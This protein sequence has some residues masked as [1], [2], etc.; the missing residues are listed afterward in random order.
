MIGLQI[1]E[2]LADGGPAGVEPVSVVM[3][4]PAGAGGAPKVNH[5]AG[6]I[7]LRFE[8]HWVH[9]MHRLQPGGPGL[10]GLG[11]GH[12]AAV[13]IHPGVVTHVLPLEGQRCFATPFQHSAECCC[14]QR[15]SCTTTGAEHHQWVGRE[16]LLTALRRESQ[17]AALQ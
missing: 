9:G 8:Q 15:F 7:A 13:L 2:T 16:A 6:R 14:H 3:L 5:L 1:L 11:V 10:Q 17:A 12:F 4:C